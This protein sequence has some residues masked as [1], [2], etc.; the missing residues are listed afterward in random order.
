MP[1]FVIKPK[2]VTYTRL[3]HSAGL[4]LIFA[5]IL[6]NSIQP[7][8]RAALLLNR[9]VVTTTSI[10]G[11]TS[12]QTFRFD[13]QSSSSVG[14]I[15]FLYCDNSPIFALLCDPPAGLDMQ[16]S[17]L[18]G[19]SGEVG[20]SDDPATTATRKVISRPASVT[21]PGAVSYVFSNVVNPTS[22]GAVYIRL[23]TYASTDG[24]GLPIDTGAVI[25]SIQQPLTVS[26]Y[27]PPFL[28]LCTGVTVQPECSSSSGF[29]VDLGELSKTNPNSATSQFAVGTNSFSGYTAS[30]QGTT[31]T[32]GNRIIPR[33][34]SLSPSVP[35]SGQFG[36]NLTQNTTPV[37]GRNV[38]GSGTG[39]VNSTYTVPNQFIFESG[40]ILAT[41]SQSTEFNR[42]TISY[43]VNIGADQSPGRYAATITVIAT[44]TF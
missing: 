6:I 42:Y 3:L 21:T 19:Q 32:A 1:D 4:F 7:S 13:I 10:P 39:V 24:T 37:V 34:S 20:F 18:T 38:E 9:S 2:H 33:L 26:V 11:Q 16:T 41:S 44:T 40:D 29:G 43:L 36:I 22:I 28:I 17:S 31:M 12:T 23:T 15:V 27:V 30:I 14:S 25:F 8:A 35:G 5:V